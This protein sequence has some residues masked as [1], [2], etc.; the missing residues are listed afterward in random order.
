M[1]QFTSFCPTRVFFQAGGLD[2]VGELLEGYNH[3][4]LVTTKGFDQ[5]VDYVDR[6]LTALKGKKVSLVNHISPNPKLEEILSLNKEELRWADGVI[7]IGGGS[8]LD[9]AKACS[10]FL[11]SS[12]DLEEALLTGQPITQPVKSIVAVPTTAGTGSELSK[13]AIMTSLRARFKGGLRGEP[14]QPTLAILDPELTLSLPLRT[15]AETGF[16]VFAHAVETYISKK[17][18]RMTE[19]F[20]REALRTVFR[21]LPTLLK[22]PADIDCRSEMMYAS[23]LMGYN[24]THA[25]SCLPHRMQYPL[26][27]KTD[28]SHSIGIASLYPAWVRHTFVK[29]EAKW[30][31]IRRLYTE[32]YPEAFRDARG[33]EFVEHFLEDIGLRSNLRSLGLSESDIPDLVERVSGSVDDDPG[34]EGQETLFRIYMESL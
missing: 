27:A 23:M 13:S 20:S 25:S 8:A 6:V 15:T 28:T 5:Q 1:I 21:S 4:V 11:S 26:G 18:N 29:S 10:L 12:V 19:L 3:L 31:E 2:R 24:L 7:G 34:F 14:L 9:A 32:A 30:T 17:S 22:F 16:D 33:Y